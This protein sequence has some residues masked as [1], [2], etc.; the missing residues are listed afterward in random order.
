MVML[1]MQQAEFAQVELGTTMNLDPGLNELT[2]RNENTSQSAVI[3]IPKTISREPKK[4]FC[5]PHVT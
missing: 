4:K 3:S 2:L 5:A 1:G